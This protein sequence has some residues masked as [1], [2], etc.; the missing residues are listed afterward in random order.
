MIEPG[1]EIVTERLLEVHSSAGLTASGPQAPDVRPVPPCAES[2]GGHGGGS[3][4][5]CGESEHGGTHR[6]FG[7]GC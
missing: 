7:G 5:P 4:Q 2:S 3:A 1:E 6:T